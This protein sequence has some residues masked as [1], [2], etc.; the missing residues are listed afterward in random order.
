MNINS[1][2]IFQ[3]DCIN[4]IGVIIDKKNLNFKQHI[5]EMCNKLSKSVG[6]LH[7]LKYYLPEEIMKR[8]Y[9]SLV[10]PYINYGIETWHGTSQSATSGVHVPQKKTIRAV[11]NLNYNDHTNE[12]IKR[13]FILKCNEI[14]KMNL[15]CYLFKMFRSRNNNY[16]A[17]NLR[18]RSELHSHN[19]RNNS[20]LFQNSTYLLH[21]N[22]LFFNQLNVGTLCHHQ[23]KKVQI[24]EYLNSN[25][26]NTSARKIY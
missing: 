6:L 24:F 9:Y 15:C 16:F 18:T 7:R 12:Y 10:Q 20:S 21:K 2:C 3:T 17:Q 13:N 4:F 14:Y 26:K 8:L 5:T 23:W 11:F 22:H 19:T 25:W 1:S